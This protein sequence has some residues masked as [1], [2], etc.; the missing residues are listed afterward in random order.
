M[1]RLFCVF[2]LLISGSL[3]A[4]TLTTPHYKIVITCQGP[5]YEVGCSKAIY[6]GTNIKT[7][8]TIKLEG[9]QIMK[10]CA[11]GVTP[12][13]SLGYKFTNGKVVYIVSEGGQLTINDGSKVLLEESGQWAD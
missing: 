3:T 11:D 2:G 13:H 9:K 12:C 8:S 1:K 7:G 4:Q 10:M 6:Q 5:E